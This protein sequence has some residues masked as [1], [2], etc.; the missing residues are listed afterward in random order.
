M[1]Q[2]FSGEQWSLI[3]V[4]GFNRICGRYSKLVVAYEGY[5]CDLPEKTNSAHTV[6]TRGDTSELLEHDLAP[7]IAISVIPKTRLFARV[8]GWHFLAKR[9]REA[10]IHLWRSYEPERVTRATFTR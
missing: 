8:Q 10:K 2:I 5:I 3:T 7:R 1:L 6:F 9:E 4:V